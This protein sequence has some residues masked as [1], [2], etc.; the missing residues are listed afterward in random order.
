MV[1]TFEFV[2]PAYMKVGLAHGQVFVGIIVFAA[3]TNA[4]A[5]SENIQTNPA[6]LAAEFQRGFTFTSGTDFV[7][8]VR[9]ITAV[10]VSITHE[11]LNS[12]H[13]QCS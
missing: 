8:F 1:G 11:F 5:E 13:Y 10:V 7:G 4:V 12:N 2:P 6:K 3:L 9:I